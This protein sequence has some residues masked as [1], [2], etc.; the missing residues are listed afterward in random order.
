MASLEEIRQERMKKQRQLEEEGFDTYSLESNRTHRISEVLDEF[1][2]M[3]EQ[4]HPVT[5][6]GRVMLL[7]EH[8]ALVFSDINDGSGG[9]Q[10]FIKK[11]ELDEGAFSQ[12]VELVDMGDFVEVTG[13]PFLTKR[14]EQSIKISSWCMLTKSLRPLPEKWHGLQDTEGRYRRR[15]LDLLMNP[16]IKELFKKKAKFWQVTR[17]FLEDKD[18]IEV[19]TPTLEL[20]TGGAEA[21]PFQTHH[22]DFDLDVYLRISVGE[23]WQKRLMAA[24]L[25]RTYEIG[26][27]YRNEGSSPEHLQEFTNC[28]FYASYLSF[29]AGQKMVTELYRRLAR[30]V[31]GATKFSTHGHD[32][33]LTDEWEQLDYVSTVKDMTGVDVL[34]A[35]RGDLEERLDE[36]GVS[37]EGDSRERLIDSLWK[38]CRKDISGPAFLINHPKLVAPLSSA[39]PEDERLTQ[40]FQVILAG[41]EIGRAHAEL[42]DPEEQRERF[43]KQQE[44]LEAGDSEAMMP[45]WEYVEMLEHGMPPVFGFGFGERFFSYLADTTIREA[46]LFP[47]MKPKER[48]TG[49]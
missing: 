32:F 14:G 3:L 42:N 7:R 38:W 47:L 17:E 9:I 43:S 41:S 33:D 29:S 19:Q 48:E 36:L 45:D 26:R 34:E 5:I 6:A 27:V 35:S 10:L 21:T 46:T 37:Y 13:I 16:E 39:H 18:F 15:Y 30:D 12:W 44:L 2:E 31:F 24:G 23:L 8:G 49:E 11:G 1:E 28:E 20:T 22:H 40:T 25:E 4:E